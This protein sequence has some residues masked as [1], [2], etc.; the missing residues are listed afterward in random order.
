MN[1]IIDACSTFGKYDYERK[2][3]LGSVLTL[4]HTALRV[5]DVALMR[6]DRISRDGDG[7]RIFLRT[8][9]NN[10][11]VFLPIPPEMVEALNSLPRPR[12]RGVRIFSGMA[13][14]Q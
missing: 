3:A 12:V 2:R 10:A 7:W 14:R 8:T 11:P 5:S 13:D 1:A 9:K 4:R 6:R